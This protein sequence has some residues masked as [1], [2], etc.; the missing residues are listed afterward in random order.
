[1]KQ[2][3][4]FTDLDGTL[5]D[6][7]TYDWHPVLPAL[8]LLR[9]RKIPVVFCSS[10]TRTEI[11]HYRHLLDN[12]DPFVAE[13]GGGIF[14]P[15]GYFDLTTLPPELV[16]VKEA[17]YAIICLGTPYHQLRQAIQELR[18]EGFALTGFGDMTVAEVAEL[19]GLTLD[20]AA[21]AKERKFDE[22]FVFSGSA[23]KIDELGAAIRARGLCLTKGAF[24]H[25]LGNSDKGIAVEI[26]ASLYRGKFGELFIIAL[27]DSRN[28]LPML[29]CADYPVAIRKPG[30]SHDP[31]L[32]MV[33][34]VKTREIGPE[35][36]NEAIF[37]LQA[38]L[39]EH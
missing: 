11:E 27:G 1:L 33:Q 18:G 23:A 9:D 32:A 13:N 25:I 26:L 5:L 15:E 17:G 38:K 8:R 10:K 6:H 36:W 39:D 4:V 37:Q 2:V 20:Q 34:P 7:A 21:M 19:T 31:D 3:V 28:D 16:I 14:L 12:R 24:F 35:G 30:G 22:P 29:Q